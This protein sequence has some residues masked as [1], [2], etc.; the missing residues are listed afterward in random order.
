M[1]ETVLLA[2]KAA[3]LLWDEK[4]RRAIGWVLVAAL[5]PVILLVMFL[6][7]LGSAMKDHNTATVSL[8]FSDA[9]VPAE[10]PEE[11]RNKIEELR[12]GFALLEESFAEIGGMFEDEDASIDT[13]QA[14]AMFYTLFLET[15]QADAR[16]F[17]DCFVNYEE[18]TRTVVVEDAEDSGEEGEG[19]SETDSEESPAEEENGSE[20]GE[21]TVTTIE[22]TYLVAIPILDLGEIWQRIG[23]LLGNAIQPE[24]QDNAENVYVI[25]RYGYL[26]GSDFEGA[27]VAY[28]GADGFCSPIGEHWRSVVTSEFGGRRDPITG[29]RD[30]HT[31]IDLAVPLGTPVRAALDGTVRTAHYNSSY[32]YYVLLD[33]GDGL[34]TLYAHCSQLLV[35]PGQTVSAGDVVALSGSTGRSTGPHLHFEVR[36]NGEQVNPRSYLP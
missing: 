28:I 17:A 14:K 1:S 13:L 12:R 22:E 5:S 10:A 33:H 19:S 27:D 36:K 31:G 7:S 4:T 8:C 9:P 34:S 26:T 23:T 11:Y 3:M 2:G 29:Q 35:S 21:E 18:R 25:A 32:G 6:C 30:G 16:S 20:D 24:Q 15:P